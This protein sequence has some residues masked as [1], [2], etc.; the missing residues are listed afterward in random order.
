MKSDKIVTDAT[1]EIVAIIEQCRRDA[2]KQG[3]LASAERCATIADSHATCEGI[4]Q[5]IAEEIRKEFKL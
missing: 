3:V 4:A 5:K 2:F 1:D